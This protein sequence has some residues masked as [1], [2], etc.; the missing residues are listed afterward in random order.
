MAELP[1]HLK[2]LE[3]LRGALDILR[4]FGVID[5]PTA[6]A[7]AIKDTLGLSDRAMPKAIR[8]LVQITIAKRLGERL[9]GLRRIGR[10]LDPAE[11]LGYVVH[12]LEGSAGLLGEPVGDL[13][14]QGR[15]SVG[16]TA[17]T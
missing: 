1:F 12:G 3:P 8:R 5:S 7:E 4:F 16:C 2:T 9:N 10:H 13:L 14:E 11:A 6:D 15:G 17:S